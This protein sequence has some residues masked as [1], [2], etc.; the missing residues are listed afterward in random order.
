MESEV[1]AEVN[2]VEIDPL[3]VDIALEYDSVLK[4]GVLI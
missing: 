1:F 4:G 2:I 3:G